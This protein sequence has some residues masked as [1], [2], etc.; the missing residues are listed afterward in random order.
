MNKIL[1]VLLH[2][3]KI[4]IFLDNHRIIKLPDKL[5]LEL[6]Y[7]NKFNKKLDLVNPKTFNEKLQWLKLYNRKDIYTTMVDKIDVKEYVSNIIGE[8]YIIPTLGIYNKFDDI[9]FE[10]L[11]KQFVIKCTHDSGGIVIVK[12]KNEFNKDKAKS[13]IN[14]S[15]K[16][17]YYYNW[18]EWPYKNVKPRIIIEKFMEDE[19]YSQLN[20]YKLMCFNGKVKCSFVCSE[21]DNIKDGLAVTFFDNDWNKMPFTRHYRNSNKE[22][23]KPYNF[24]KMIDLAERLAKDI[25]FVRIDF[26]EINKKIYF[27]EVTFFPGAGIEEFNPEKWDEII[28]GWI[29]LNSVKK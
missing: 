11:P 23:R 27:G 1:R 13:I 9:D 28:G 17:N 21:R 6:M 14:K 3:S 25:P 15:L 10:K 8:E 22:I 19:K 7:K 4:L 20:D 18:R 24:T 12:D 5:Y 29:D 26:Y 2:P 16:N